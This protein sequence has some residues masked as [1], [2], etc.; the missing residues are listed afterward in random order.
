MGANQNTGQG[1]Q[2]AQQGAQQPRVS[3]VA[4][5]QQQWQYMQQF[6]QT[7]DQLTYWGMQGWRLVG[8][9]VIAQTTLG[10]SGKLLYVFERPI[11]RSG[12][13]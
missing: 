5:T 1:T 10:T 13:Q 2:G 12:S 8:P 9:P 11:M 4:E 6:D 7:P 3:L